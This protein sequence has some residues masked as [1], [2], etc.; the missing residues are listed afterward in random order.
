MAKDFKDAG[1]ADPAHVNVDDPAEV[2][3]WCTHWGCSESE[4]KRA[5]KNSAS[6][7]A[8]TV[9]AYLQSNGQKRK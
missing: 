4:L 8:A 6:E 9:E 7:I 2:R 1:P 5:V 3:Y